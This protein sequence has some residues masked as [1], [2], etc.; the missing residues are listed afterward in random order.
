MHTYSGLLE[1]ACGCGVVDVMD[2]A[3]GKK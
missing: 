2:I 1:M 3:G